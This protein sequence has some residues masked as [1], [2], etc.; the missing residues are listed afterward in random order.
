MNKLQEWIEAALIVADSNGM[1]DA[2]VIPTWPA[3]V[4][5]NF[6]ALTV[7]ALREWQAERTGGEP[8]G[9][10]HG[11]DLNKIGTGHPVLVY[12]LDTPVVLDSKIPVFTHPPAKVPEILAA[13]HRGIRISAEGVLGRVK[14]M[15]KPMSQE[16]LK[17][18][19]EMSESF[20]SGNVKAVDQFLQTWDLDAKRPNPPTQGDEA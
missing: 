15:L 20:Y 9:W 8:L 11:K 4:A 12:N 10:I 13:K 5:D 3:D 18:L 1:D 7:G 2:Q 17:Q 16:M 14:G 6:P 19:Q